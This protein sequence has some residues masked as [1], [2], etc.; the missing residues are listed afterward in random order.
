MT[1]TRR[2][3]RVTGIPAL[4]LLLFVV[5]VIAGLLVYEAWSTGRSRREIA[6]RGLQDYAAYATWSTARA[7]DLAVGASLSMLFRGLVSSRIGSDADLP[8]LSTVVNAAKE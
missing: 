7:G 2:P 3:M 4:G 1:S 8:S 6:Q 5:F